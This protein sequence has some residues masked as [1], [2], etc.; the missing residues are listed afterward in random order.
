M[1]ERADSSKSVLHSGSMQ[2]D[3]ASTPSRAECLGLHLYVLSCKETAISKVG[4]ATS[5]G[6]RLLALK[7]GCPFKLEVAK[8]YENCGEYEHTVHRHLRK[9]RMQGE[10]F[11]APATELLPQ[12]DQLVSQLEQKKTKRLDRERR[13]EAIREYRKQKRHNK[14]LK[15]RF[16]EIASL[17]G[18]CRGGFPLGFTSQDILFNEEFY[19]YLNA[20]FGP[21]RDHHLDH[22]G[23]LT[24]ELRKIECRPFLG[25]FLIQFGHDCTGSRVRW[26]ILD[27]EQYEALVE[28]EKIVR[29]AEMRAAIKRL[30]EYFAKL[31]SARRNA[32]PPVISTRGSD[33]DQT[34]D[35]DVGTREIPGETQMALW[36]EAPGDSVVAQAFGRGD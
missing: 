13:S 7:T 22:S 19:P 21:L 20:L 2:P 30:D 35:Q 4:R 17:L 8:T 31:D 12:I 34:C 23:W 36:F 6:A 9:L 24:V 28:S 33:R 5:V 26:C 3:A 25:V 32:V 16:K 14:C 18:R 27:T 11:S 15:L 10:W 1:H 29:R